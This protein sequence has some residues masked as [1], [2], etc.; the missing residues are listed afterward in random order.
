MY[1][2]RARRRS[3][4]DVLVFG[5]DAEWYG[6][7]VLI[8]ASL[9]AALTGFGMVADADYSLGDTWIAIAIAGFLS[10]FVLGAF[11]I[12]P[13]LKRVRVAREGGD[14][15]LGASLIG[16]IFMISRIELVVLVVVVLD[17]VIK[18]GA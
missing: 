17:M 14:E 2:I 1:A 9:I 15:S 3:H 6:N 13:T 10:S 5:Y 11:L 8:P 4:N 7:R 16:R 12:G 18:P